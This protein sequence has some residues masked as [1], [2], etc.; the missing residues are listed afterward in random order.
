MKGATGLALRL[1][2]LSDFGGDVADQSRH[3]FDWVSQFRPMEG[4]ALPIVDLPWSNQCSHSHLDP[5]V[6]GASVKA[7]TIFATQN[8]TEA[9]KKVLN[10]WLSTWERF[11]AD[12]KDR[13]HSA[14]RIGAITAA[15]DEGDALPT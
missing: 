6:G 14:E 15:L 1:D 4:P 10:R 12:E 3:P 11:M 9:H 7:L 13:P 2:A 8:R 5:A